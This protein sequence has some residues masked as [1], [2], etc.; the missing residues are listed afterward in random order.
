MPQGL[1]IIGESYV[2]KVP[3]FVMMERSEASQDGAS[4][5]KKTPATLRSFVVPIT[6][7]FSRMT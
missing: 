3:P 5:L 6:R 4:Q 2:E 1:C 7:D